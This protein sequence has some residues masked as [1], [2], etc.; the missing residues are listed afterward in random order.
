M[1]ASRVRIP[2]P[3]RA[4]RRPVSYEKFGR[5]WT[6]PWAWIRDRDDPEVLGHLEA[7]NAWT[8]RCLAPWS[9]VR[10]AVLQEMKSRIVPDTASPPVRHGPFL[11]FSRYRRGEEYPVF[12]RRRAG[13]PGRRAG[14]EELLLDGNQLAREAHGDAA[15]GYFSLGALEICPEHRILA[16]ATDPVEMQVARSGLFG[17]GTRQGLQGTVRDHQSRIESSLVG[18]KREQQPRAART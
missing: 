12:C 2:G 17:H 18:D 7:E 8:E 11:Y 15:D 10:D 5:R 13:P 4:P 1:T 16:F 6:D 3:P 14:R 9:G